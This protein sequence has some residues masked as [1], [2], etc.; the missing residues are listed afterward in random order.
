MLRIM[1]LTCILLLI[2][3]Q[4]CSSSTE[5]ADNTILQEIKGRERTEAVYRAKVPKNWIRRDPL[6]NADLT[7]TTQAICEFIIMNDGMTSR[8]A[9]HSFPTD[10]IEGQIAPEAQ[11]DR[12]KRQFTS[13]AP[14]DYIVNSIV[15]NGY[16]GLYF[17][18]E[19]ILHDTAKMVLAWSLVIAPEHY[20]SLLYSSGTNQATSYKEMRADITIKAIGQPA[21]IKRHEEEII[22]FAQSFELINEIPLRL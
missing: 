1:T 3:L 13:L 19:G 10:T 22:R 5:S 9:I 16:I 18:G 8:I 12:W 2:L 17:K 21:H 15:Y 4:S 14:T 11:V 6:P 7:D 20:R